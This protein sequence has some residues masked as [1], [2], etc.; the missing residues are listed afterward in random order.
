M[1][2]LNPIPALKPFRADKIPDTGIGEPFIIPAILDVEIGAGVGMFAIAYAHQNSQRS[3][4]A[5]EHGNTRFSRFRRRVAHHDHLPNLTIVQA[6]A[7]AWISHQ[8]PPL[9]VD[10][11]FL[12]YPNPYPKKSQTNKRWHAMPFME[13]LIQTLKVGGTITVATNERFYADEVEKYYSHYWNL[14]QDERKIVD[15]NSG[16]RT[17]FE[18]KYLERGESCYNFVF[19]KT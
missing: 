9:S 14:L 11:Y 8:L 4:V 15:A 18:R 3:I 7:V 17:H 6:D 1:L 13:K 5:I 12:L 10:R 2:D 19:K 16:G